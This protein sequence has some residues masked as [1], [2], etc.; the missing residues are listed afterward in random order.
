MNKIDRLLMDAVNNRP[1]SF[2]DYDFGKLPTSELKEMLNADTPNKR[3]LEIMEPVRVINTSGNM[4][5][6]QLAK[7]IVTELEELKSSTS[8]LSGG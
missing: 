4:R 6:M 2:I 7:G 3:V 1:I 8:Q 5:R